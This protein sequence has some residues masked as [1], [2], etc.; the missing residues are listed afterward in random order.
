MESED[1]NCGCISK[2]RKSS[3]KNPRLSAI[4]F[5]PVITLPLGP[6]AHSEYFKGKRVLVTGATRGIGKNLVK[7]L[8]Y[9][10]AQVIA[11]GRTEA[12]LEILCAEV[13]GLHPLFIDIS[14][15]SALERKLSNIGDIDFLV[16]CAG[17][18]YLGSIL[19]TTEDQFDEI[20]N[21]N[22]KDM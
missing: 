1:E 5:T 12:D 18:S 6:V 2:R 11:L 3:E 22:T 8:H 13:S 9:L 10:G 4:N 16:N 7:N 14:K 21:I 19:N 15:W 17:V 20:F